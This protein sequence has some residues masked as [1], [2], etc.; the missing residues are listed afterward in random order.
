[1]PESSVWDGKEL[2]RSGRRRSGATNL[3]GLRFD[4]L[5]AEEAV[6]VFYHYTYEGSVDIDSV[7]DPAMKASF[8]SLIAKHF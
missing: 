6:N 7:T 2:Q 1:M 3:I 4:D 8:F 5:E